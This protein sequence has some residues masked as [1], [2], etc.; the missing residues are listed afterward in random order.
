MTSPVS[1]PR[2]ELRSSTK[3]YADG[4][5]APAWDVYLDDLLVAS[6]YVALADAR[7]ELDFAVWYGLFGDATLNEN[8]LITDE[9][10]GLAMQVFNRLFSAEKIQEKARTA[11]DKIIAAG[12]FSIQSDGS[13]SVLAS[14]S[15]GKQ[16][17]YT[18]TSTCTCKDFFTHAHLRSGVCKHIA[19]RML[20]VLSQHGVGYLKHLRDALDAHSAIIQRSAPIATAPTATD[21]PVESIEWGT[22]RMH[23]IDILEKGLNNQTPVIYDETEDGGRV[24]N[25]KETLLVREKLE[26]I[27]EAWTTWVW[28]DA[29]R[30]DRLCRIYNELFNSSRR[31]DFSGTHLSLPGINTTVLRG[32]D[33]AVHQ[34]DAVWMILQTASVL[35]DLC[36]GAGKTFIMLA[37]A[38]ELKHLGL[39]RKILITVPNHLTEQWASEANRL[40]PDMRV[41]AMSADDFSK[42]RRGTFLS[43]IATQ[44]WDVIICAHTSFGFI[45]TGSIAKEYIQI[46]VDE[47]RF[48]LE[49]MRR[50][51]DITRTDKRTMKEIERKIL[52]FEN[53]LKEQEYRVTH[54]DA[55]IITW[56]ELGI[57]TLMVDEAH[58]FKNL[59]VPTMLGS[60]PGVPKGDSKRA[61]DMRIKTWDLRRRGGRVV[62]ATGTPVLNTLGE[63]FIMQKYLQED[64]LAAHGIEHFDA[65]ASTFAETQT[66][67]EMTPD[68]GG[69]RMN[70]RLCKF[71]NL[72]ELFNLWFQMTF[73]RSREQLGLPTPTLIGGKPI[74]VSVPGSPTLKALVRS[75]VS[76]VEAIKSGAVE[77]WDDNML[78]V[79]SDGR[80]AALDV[81]LIT[82]GAEEP[83][84]KI[85]MLVNT[86]AELHHRYD[87]AK[88]TQLI[89]CELSTPKPQKQAQDSS[90]D[91]DEAA[92]PELDKS[93]VYHEIRAK[94]AARGVPYEQVAFIQEHATKT[95]RAALF[96]AM[97]RGDVRVLIASK[98]STGMNI[99]QRLIALHNLDAP[100]RPGDLEQRIGRI[101][102]QGNGWPEV[103]VCNY[104]TE[105]SFDG[106]IWQTLETKARFIGQMRSGDVTIRAIDDISEVVL[107]AA[108]IKAI[109]SGN[110]KVI[111]KVQLDAELV[112][113][114]SLHSSYRDTQARMRAKLR[115]IAWARERMAERRALLLAAEHVVTPFADA[116]FKA[117]IVKG[118]MTNEAI[119]YTKRDAAGKALNAI[120]VEVAAQAQA[121]KER[122]TRTIGSYQGLLIRAQASPIMAVADVFLSVEHNGQIAAI[123]GTLVKLG[124]DQGVFASIDWQIRDISE[125]TQRIDAEGVAKDQEEA[126]S[127]VALTLPWDQ[128][129]R[130]TAVQAELEA[131][132]VELSKASSDRAPQPTTDTTQDTPTITAGTDTGALE[133]VGIS[134][135]DAATLE[136]AAALPLLPPAALPE[137]GDWAA[138]AAAMAQLATTAVL[139]AAEEAT[140]TA[141]LV[142]T[143]D[144]EEQTGAIAA[145][146][147]VEE[148]EQP[149]IQP[150]TI[151]LAQSDVVR[152]PGASRSTLVFGS[153]AHIGLVKGKRAK[154]AKATKAPNAELATTIDVFAVADTPA[155]LQLALF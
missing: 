51:S 130:Y 49:E 84:C 24:V 27:K 94:L 67:F 126:Q 20:L 142:D 97:N 68:G 116:A 135:V 2:P 9:A 12:I 148:L 92:D 99:Q 115:D 79:T 129:E 141:E 127:S 90:I 29:G 107:S 31:R 109:A 80:K 111:R 104:V 44:E 50:K 3:H 146:A 151:L 73:S 22:G 76:R 77:P 54:D 63:V 14:S 138:M 114:A 23:A 132:N 139:T 28:E 10:L 46:E 8:A 32:G 48:Y 120:A 149:E 34:K 70:T 74:P 105:G 64:V 35:L 59:S 81:R 136:V 143:V 121:T 71:V 60:L 16:A 5:S 4:D 153:Q 53:R 42:E 82:G 75:F 47:L 72:P 86:V 118:A 128:A 154:T 6:E 39:A 65:W 150:R 152:V 30:T 61:F 108:E 69:F 134:D 137:P 124:S 45:E 21:T 113:L 15:R 125:A 122:I 110:P 11:R 17:T 140:I 91:G 155:P 62:F 93:F 101:E 55:R 52:A 96:A 95:R 56:D 106:Y 58:E 85:N 43:R 37:A 102:R 103:F 147:A 119:A 100:W 41:L 19:A 98:Q 83:A 13:L 145:E 38:H 117:A 123:T 26:R 57:D 18:V 112:K 36:V 87:A 78:K 40:Y 33:L 133:V 131:L 88:A 7:M 144:A 89:Y 66:V 25:Q 1:L